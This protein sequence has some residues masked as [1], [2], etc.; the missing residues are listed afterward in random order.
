MG[1]ARRCSTLLDASGRGC[2]ALL[3]VARHWCQDCPAL[4]DDARRTCHCHFLRLFKLSKNPGTGP[5]PASRAQ[6]LAKRIK[7]SSCS[8]TVV[9]KHFMQYKCCPETHYARNVVKKRFMQYKCCQSA[10]LHE[11][12]ARGRYLCQ[13][14]SIMAARSNAYTAGRKRILP[15]QMNA[16]P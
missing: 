6:S 7:R 16:L 13:M 15:D 10:D 12:L 5:R 11:S 14:D 3:D 4:L 9:Q 1:C 8:T 2:S